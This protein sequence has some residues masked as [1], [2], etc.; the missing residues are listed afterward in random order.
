MFW[1]EVPNAGLHLGGPSAGPTI[2]SSYIDGETIVVPSDIERLKGWMVGRQ[3]AG[4]CNQPNSH[5]LACLCA[6]AL[7]DIRLVWPRAAWN[8]LPALTTFNSV[9][10]HSN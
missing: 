7:K 2:T 8:R 5:V 10:L 9:K 3:T 4:S 1:G 6:H